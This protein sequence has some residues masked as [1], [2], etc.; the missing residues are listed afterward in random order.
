MRKFFR[1][2]F[3]GKNSLSVASIILIITLFLSNVLGV[4][5]DHYLTQKIPTDV[6]STYYA[7]FRIPDLLFN[8]LILGAISAAFIPVFSSLISNKREK[9]AWL[10]ANSVINIAIVSL[11]ISCFILAII[12]PYLVPLFV[13][14]FSHEEQLSTVKLARIMLASPVFFG[15]SYIFGAI[16]NS[17]KR[18]AVYALAPLVYNVTIILGTLFLADRYGIT[19]VALA[20]VAGAFLHM[21]IQIPVALRLG[22]KWQ[23][24][25]DV[26]SSFVRRIGKLM[27]PRALG[28]GANQILLLFFTTIA[29]S[30]GGSAVAVYN[31]SD[32]IQTMPMVV[33]GTSFA[34]AIFP[35]LSEK[36]S[37]KNYEQFSMYFLKSLRSILF[38]MI[39]ISF[40]V[41]LLR[42]QIVRMILGSGHFGWSQTNDTAAL[43]GFF[44]LALVFT[45]I[46]PLL[47]RSFY[48]LHNTKIP[49]FIT[50]I[51][52]AVSVFAGYLLAPKMGISGLAIAYS[53]GSLFNA[54]ALYILLRTRVKIDERSVIWF[55]LKVLI[56][57]LIMAAAIWEAIIVTNVFNMHRF[58][59][60]FAQTAISA[61]VG[62]FVFFVLAWIFNCEEIASVKIVLSRLTGRSLAENTNEPGR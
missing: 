38:F 33:F 16:L 4:I 41:Y 8:V 35:T 62:I 37:E 12:M 6:L 34:M 50:I 61:S 29:S 44:A 30:L 45:S 36:A 22:F 14:G 21:A 5:R 10:T 11:I 52:V 18:F 19:G 40:G 20:V 58:W 15:L 39:P 17:Y 32:N 47:A 27:L 48:A 59:G 9:E 3:D 23:L 31:L 49:M 42:K 56:A 2:F 13:P 46:I 26:K 7:A 25:L 43:L 54:L 28:L 53:L 55:L 57:S 24:V 51:T 60:V 1:N